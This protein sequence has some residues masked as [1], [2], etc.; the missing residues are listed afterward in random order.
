MST[1]LAHGCSCFGL[2]SYEYAGLSAE[3]ATNAVPF[4]F[5][6]NLF[7]GQSQTRGTVCGGVRRVHDT[8]RG[9]RRGDA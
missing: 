4:P 3:D 6:L 8:T 9:W 5:N 2:V 1:L 7:R